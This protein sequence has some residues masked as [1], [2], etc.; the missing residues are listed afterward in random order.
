MEPN[1]SKNLVLIMLFI[2]LLVN[3]SIMLT[4]YFIPRKTQQET[5]FDKERQYQHKKKSK[6][7]LM[8]NLQLS[9]EQEISF[10]ELRNA[11]REKMFIRLD[12]I[13]AIRSMMMDKL[14]VETEDNNI[15]NY[16][17]LAEQIGKLEKEVQ[18]STIEYFLQVKI[19]LTKEQ[20]S[21]FVSHF[22]EICG[23]KSHH[24]KKNIHH[25]RKKCPIEN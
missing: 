4:L 11:H 16:H 6:R 21:D 13:N 14:L 22:K 15:A 3:I 20:F 1:K 24:P 9:A 7:C 19:I 25:K 8:T 18:L 2:L 10:S 23:C 17:A 5:K 12:S